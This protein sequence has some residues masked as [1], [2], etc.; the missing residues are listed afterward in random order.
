V[1]RAARVIEHHWALA[2]GAQSAAGSWRER[3]A[4]LLELRDE[5]GFFGLGEAAPLPGFAADSLEAARDALL[6]L[7]AQPLPALEPSSALV[8]A[9][10]AAGAPLTSPSARSALESALLDL[11]AHRAQKPAWSLLA[12]T[13][14]ARVPLALWLPSGTDAALDA[15]RSALARGVAAF[16]VKLDGARGF[17]SGVAT[18]E[19]LRGALGPGIALRA[20]A[21]QS[22]TRAMLEP[23]LGR[24]RALELE[25]LEEPTRASLSEDLGIPLALDESLQPG[26]ATPDLAE[27][28]RVRALVLKPTAL[29][30]LARCVGL[31]AQARAHGRSA[32]AS[33]ALEGPLGFMAAASLAISLGESPAHGLAPHAALRGRP[34]ALDPARDELI[35]WQAHGFGLTVAEALDGATVERE[36][37]P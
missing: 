2:A 30:G 36:H 8:G 35:G 12:P 15:A 11:A 22:G 19:A 6:S 37:R 32:V 20:D 31:A 13:S 10:E 7:L 25:W 26:S 3:R 28:P 4:L 5:D 9:L 34:P 16:K 24:L 23:Y 29:G 27:H 14:P 1:I 21:N 18:L 33:H 17:E